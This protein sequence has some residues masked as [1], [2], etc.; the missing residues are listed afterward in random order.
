[1]KYGILFIFLLLISGCN[2]EEEFTPNSKY[3]Y[4]PV[5]KVWQITHVD[6]KFPQNQNNLTDIQSRYIFTD[7]ITFLSLDKG[8][9]YLKYSTN[10][11]STDS[12]SFTLNNNGTI[13]HHAYEVTGMYIMADASPPTDADREKRDEL[14]P[15][16]KGKFLFLKLKNKSKIRIE[17]KEMTEYL[18]L[19]N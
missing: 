19:Y 13:D 18:L 17:G 12:I 10:H 7:S 15:E 6:D 4:A 1:M 9:S 2:K 16:L 14:F 3:L 5:W 8:V 11:L